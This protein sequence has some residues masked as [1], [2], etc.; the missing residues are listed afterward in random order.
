MI[1]G[2]VLAPVGGI[3]T[4]VAAIYFAAARLIRLRASVSE[5]PPPDVAARLEE[6]ERTVQ[7]LA[8]ELADTQERLDF[9]ERVLTKAQEDRRIGG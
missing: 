9:T 4:I 3:V 5:S 1:P 7:G 2:V 8:R 6:L